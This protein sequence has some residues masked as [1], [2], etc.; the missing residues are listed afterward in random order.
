MVQSHVIFMQSAVKSACYRM[1]SAVRSACI[2]SHLVACEREVDQTGQSAAFK[3]PREAL[4]ALVSHV[5]RA[6][7]EVQQFLKGA[8][9]D[10]HRE[11]GERIVAQ[12]IVH[13][14]QVL[15]DR[16][17]GVLVDSAN[18]AHK[19]LVAELA[20]VEHEHPQV[21]ELTR[22]RCI[23]RHTRW[24]RGGQVRSKAMGAA[25]IVT[26]RAWSAAEFVREGEQPRVAQ[27]VAR[28]L[29]L[30]HVRHVAA[31]VAQQHQVHGSDT[32]RSEV[33]HG[34]LHAACE[35]GARAARAHAP[36]HIDRNGEDV[37]LHP[38]EC[39]CSEPYSC[40]DGT[41]SLGWPAAALVHQTAQVGTCEP[42]AVEEGPHCPD[43]LQRLACVDE[44]AHALALIMVRGVVV[45]A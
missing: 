30:C 13:A 17:E 32:E 22:S 28:E 7:V 39:G 21:D 40:A 11:R 33:A 9:L 25:A 15:E 19:A 41:N 18:E 35:V 43:Q 26:G 29:E 8:S 12:R 31:R 36:E 42:R 10:S 45:E 1:Q 14:A 4:A 23:G 6:K 3:G 20:A 24:R 38:H 34:A 27:W 37:Q 5:V 16:E 2:P 44:T